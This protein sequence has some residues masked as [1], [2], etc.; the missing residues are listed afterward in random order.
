MTHLKFETGNWKIEGGI[1]RVEF[2]SKFR[3]N[4]VNIRAFIIL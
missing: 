4:A 2:H 3:V 1:V